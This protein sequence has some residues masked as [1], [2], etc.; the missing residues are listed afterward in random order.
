VFTM[1]RYGHFVTLLYESFKW[2]YSDCILLPL[3]ENTQAVHG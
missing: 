2:A 1:G 3:G